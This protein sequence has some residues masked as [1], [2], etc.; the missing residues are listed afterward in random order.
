ML[1][2]EGLAVKVDGR[3]ILRGVDLT[4]SHGETHVLLGPNGS[5]K[6]TLLGAIMGM[7]RYQVTE[8]RILFKGEDVTQLP[9]PE[10]ARR[11]MG[12]AFQRPPAVRGVTLRQMADLCL[13]NADR[14]HRDASEAPDV[15]DL[16]ASLQVEPLLGR[17]VNSGFSGGEAKRAELLQLLAQRPTLALLDEPESGV[18]LT[19]IAVVGAAI[20]ALLEKD[21]LRSRQVAGLI[22]THTGHILDYVPADRAHVLM[23]GRIV[24]AGNPRELLADIRRNGY[25]RCA[26]CTR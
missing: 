13:R 23:E 14:S 16:A 12:L 24:C 3:E 10:R 26:G 15:D 5:G 22:I 21:R 8:G 11:G 19:N 9:L 1:R 7:G 6:T 17:D 20:N 4:I 2:V 25:G 18:D